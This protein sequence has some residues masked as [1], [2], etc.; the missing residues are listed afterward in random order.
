MLI[1][2]INYPEKSHNFTIQFFMT[3]HFRTLLLLFRGITLINLVL[4]ITK[5]IL[6]TRLH[7]K[8]TFTI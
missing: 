3:L 8:A 7:N 6:G 1:F 5:K 2:Q 4:T